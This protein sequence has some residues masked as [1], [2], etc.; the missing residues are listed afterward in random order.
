MKSRGFHLGATSMDR[1]GRAHLRTLVAAAIV[2][3]VASAVTTAQQVFTV[4]H[5]FA[6]G[7][8]GAVPFASLILATDG[9]FYGTTVSGGITSS[10]CSSDGCGTVSR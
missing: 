1:R 2:V 10:S 5:T 7:T 9:N 6:G 8:D 3:V 4:L